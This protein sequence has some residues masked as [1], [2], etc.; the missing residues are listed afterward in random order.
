MSARCLRV[1]ASAAALLLLALAAGAA[2][3]APRGRPVEYQGHFSTFPSGMRLVVYER[4]SAPEFMFAVSYR[5]GASD[6]PAGKEGIAHVAEHLLFRSAPGVAGSPPIWDRL[7]SSGVRFNAFTDWDSTVLWEVGK[8]DQ[9]DAMLTL[10]AGRM[11]DPLA[12]VAE[13]DF[14]AERE[15]VVNEIRERVAE[16]STSALLGLLMEASF[17]GHPYGR[18]IAGTV[19]SVR[20]VGLDDVRAWMRGHFTPAHAVLVLSSPRPAP[21]AVR[22]VLARFGELA[23]PAGDLQVAS[24]ERVPPP[25]PPDPPDGAPLPVRHAQ[26]LTPRLLVGWAVPGD[27]S[28]T[29]PQAFAAA[30]ALQVVTG[31]RLGQPDARDMVLAERLHIVPLDGFSLILQAFDLRRE[32]DAPKVLE[33]VKNQLI[34]LALARPLDALKHEMDAKLLTAVTVASRSFLLAQSYLEIEQLDAPAVAQF[35]R[36]TRQPDY[37]GGFP[38]QVAATLSTSIDGYAAKYLTRKRA[39]AMLLLPDRN[40]PARAIAGQ[41]AT[42]VAPGVDVLDDAEAR[43]LTTAGSVESIARPPG[44]DRAERRKLSNGL[45]VVVAKRG[46]LPIAEVRLLVRTDPE[47]GARVPP[48]LPRLALGS[49]RSH[50]DKIRWGKSWRVGADFRER[51]DADRLVL[52]FRGSAGNLPDILYDLGLWVNSISP[53]DRV[54]EHHRDTRALR[55]EATLRRPADRARTLL[56]AR[57]FPDKPYGRTATPEGIRALEFRQTKRWIDQQLRPERATLLV[58]GDVE[59]MEDTWKRIETELGGWGKG[60]ALPLAEGPAA[61]APP[62]RRSV[63]LFDRPGATQAAIAVGLRL[64]A[65]AERDAAALEAVRWQLRFAIQ[66]RLRVQEGVT[67]GVQVEPIRLALA[68]AVI[69]TTSVEQAAGGHALQRILESVQGLAGQPLAA[70]AAARARWQVARDYAFQFDTVRDVQDRLEESA[71]FRLPPDHWERLAT[72][73]ASLTAERIQAAARSLGP[74]NE[75]VVVVGDQNALLPQLKAAGYQVETP[76]P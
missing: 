57:L 53:D 72:S 38:R 21:D 59:P 16:G 66:Q 12:G 69:V 65:G 45:E 23:V 8:P 2:G 7:L 48:G 24:V 64:P 39:I 34:D 1:A 14:L 74:G 10:E 68:E 49:S 31:F 32:E 50:M 75:V 37:I 56:A 33:F 6:E 40:L 22:A 52:D 70:A 62:S 63:T 73:I 58:V 41:P 3:P 35:L 20:R 36:A 5:A 42:E 15:V 9:L 13:R 29:T 43:L 18:P 60:D 61:A 30:Q 67:Y 76:P 27:Y 54:F 17:P 51:L 55:L 46:S 19:E 44:L 28:G 47:G 25:F 4:P 26:V 71:L 11:R